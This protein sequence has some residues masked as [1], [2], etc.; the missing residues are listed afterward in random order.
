MST[1]LIVVIISQYIHVSQHHVG[2][3]L[4]RE[5]ENF[6]DAFSFFELNVNEVQ[7]YQSF[8]EFPSLCFKK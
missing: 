2:H 4:F 8:K 5:I 3:H 6:A 7:Q 1:N